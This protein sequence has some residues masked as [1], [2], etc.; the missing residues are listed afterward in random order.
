MCLNV[1]EKLWRWHLIRRMAARPICIILLLPS[2]EITT[3]LHRLRERFRR[4]IAD[5]LRRAR[6]SGRFRW[7]M[8]MVIDFHSHYYEA[9]WF[10]ALPQRQNVF[11]R[12]WP[13]LS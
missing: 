12:A 9:N 4:L 10:S 13:L 11:T 5:S 1:L 6:R 7:S 8:V 2:G 3:M